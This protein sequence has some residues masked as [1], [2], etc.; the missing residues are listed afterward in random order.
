MFC[1]RQIS[2][3]G[4]RLRTSHLSSYLHPSYLLPGCASFMSQTRA[5]SGS[6]KRKA[7]DPDDS[8]HAPA[9]NAKK[10]KVHSSDDAEKSSAS[11]N[12]QPTNKVLPTVMNFPTRSADVLRMVAWNVTSL[13]SSQKKG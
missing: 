6:S 8:A 7:S 12:G 3:S 11:S 10:S 5:I 9:V 1:I 13:A 2:S 4:H